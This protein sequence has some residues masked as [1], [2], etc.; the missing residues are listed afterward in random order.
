[1]ADIG[2]FYEDDEPVGEVVAAFEAGPK[3]FTGRLTGWTDYLRLPSLWASS[4]KLSTS[5]EP[6]KPSTRGASVRLSHAH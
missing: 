6:S 1:M 3:S 4:T 2:D 5:E